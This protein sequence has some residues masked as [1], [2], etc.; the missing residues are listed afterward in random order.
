MSLGEG[1]QGSGKT[2]KVSQIKT[3]M[4]KLPNFSLFLILCLWLLVAFI[5]SYQRRVLADP[6]YLF[7][8]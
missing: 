7:S 1:N 2:A 3:R 6:I 8:P 5:D 4:N